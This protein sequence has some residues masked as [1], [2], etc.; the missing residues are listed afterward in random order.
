[1]AQRNDRRSAVTVIRV[2]IT[3]VVDSGR[4][5]CRALS[6]IAHVAANQDRVVGP[7]LEPGNSAIVRTWIQD[8]HPLVA[9]ARVEVAVLE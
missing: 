3:L 5:D 4:D 6:V 9:E 2:E 1:M 8:H 7:D